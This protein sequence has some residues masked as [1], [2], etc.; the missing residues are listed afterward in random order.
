MKYSSALVL[1]I[2]FSLSL[3]VC[4]FVQQVIM[5]LVKFRLTMNHE[6]HI[7]AQ[8]ITMGN[9]EGTLK[10]KIVACFFLFSTGMLNANS[11]FTGR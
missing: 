10:P 2:T 1:L 8:M 5:K 6:H 7:V 3:V 4:R 11:Q 9:F